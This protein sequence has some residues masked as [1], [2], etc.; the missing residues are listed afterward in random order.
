MLDIFFL[1]TL[2]ARTHVYLANVAYIH[3]FPDFTVGCV[4]PNDSGFVIE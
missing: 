1:H 2:L 4:S 3:P